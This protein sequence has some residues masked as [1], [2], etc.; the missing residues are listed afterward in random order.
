[1]TF[2]VRSIKAQL[3]L[4]L[5][6]LALFVCVLEKD[7]HF[8]IRLTL[9]LGVAVVVEAAVLFLKTKKA[10]VTESAIIAGLIVGFVIAGTQ[11]WWKL[12]AATSLA[13]LS[14]YFLRLRNKHLFNPA[15]FGLLTAAV[16]FGASMQWNA[17]YLWY[18]LVPFGF[19]FAHKIRRLEVIAGY[20][21][22]SIVLFGIQ[23]L[24]QGAALRN[25]FG[26]FSYFYIFIMLIEP[27]T[28]PIPA[29]AKFVFGA[30]AGGLVFILSEMNVALDI[31]LAALLA[32]NA[33]VPL[34]NRIFQ[35]QPGGHV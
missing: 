5:L 7:I 23:A 28:T 32:M 35:Q 3:I 12:V 27:K 25:I 10:R 26:Y 17:T 2:F 30:L 15:A 9:C 1:M 8:L 11:P 22:I 14:K 31:E 13:I 29:R 6:G 4:F 16:F 19:Y 34:V 20:A 33:A 18:F 24:M 21:A